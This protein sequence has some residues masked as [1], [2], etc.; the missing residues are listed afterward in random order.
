MCVLSLLDRSNRRCL[1][2]RFVQWATE[3]VHTGGGGGPGGIPGTVGLPPEQQQQMVYAALLSDKNL[4]REVRR[5][6][7]ASGRLCYSATVGAL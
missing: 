5:Q 3:V 4:L 6:L 7:V 1:W 2:V